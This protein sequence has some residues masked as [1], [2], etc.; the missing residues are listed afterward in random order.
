MPQKSELP[1]RCRW[2]VSRA[3]REAQAMNRAPMNQ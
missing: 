1:M 2:P 3:M